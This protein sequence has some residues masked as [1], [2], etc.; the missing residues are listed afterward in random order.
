MTLPPNKRGQTHGA[1]TGNCGKLE[2]SG[3]SQPRRLLGKPLGPE[4]IYFRRG[5]GAFVRLEKIVMPGQFGDRRGSPEAQDRVRH[6]SA[7]QSPVV[8][9]LLVVVKTV[10]FGER[11]SFAFRKAI[12]RGERIS[13]L[14]K[15]V[16]GI[17]EG[18]K[19][20]RLP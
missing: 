19:G 3:S 7:L 8:G 10:V 9:Q 14:S 4:R 18:E 6:G 13:R 16:E 1:G 20:L 15:L 2:L 17:E 5:G 11:K 12:D